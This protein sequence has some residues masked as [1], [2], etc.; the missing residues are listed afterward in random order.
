[1]IVERDKIVSIDYIMRNSRGEVLE[2][3]VNSGVTHYLHG[4]SGIHSYLQSQLEGLHIGD[5]KTVLLPNE[6]S[7]TGDDFSFEVIIRQIRNAKEEELQLG[8]PVM[9]ECREDCDCY[10]VS[11]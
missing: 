3:T 10:H 5:M 8:Y 1:M 7:N 11:K 6:I 4:S 2:D 9:A